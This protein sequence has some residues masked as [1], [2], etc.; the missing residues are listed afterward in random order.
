MEDYGRRLTLLV[1]QQ[2][3]TLRVEQGLSLEALA[4]IAGLH[5][6]SVGLVMRGKRGMTLASAAA[7]SAALRVRLSEVVVQAERELQGREPDD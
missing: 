7:I 6:T 4:A 2:L 5:R 3:R 1:V